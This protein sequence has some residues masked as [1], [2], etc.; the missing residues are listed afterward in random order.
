MTDKPENPTRRTALRNLGLA[1]LGATAAF[2]TT[3]AS[4]QT[5]ASRPL[6]GK[7]AI[8]TGARNNQGRAFCAALAE[9]GA[10]VVVHYHRAET[11]GEAEETARMVREAGAKAALIQGDL[12]ESANVKALYDL[13]EAEFGGA[14]IVINTA[15]TI[16]KKPMADFTDD[17]F[18]RLV[19]DNTK[20]TFYSM[21]EAARRLRDGGR[22]INIGTS[23]TAGAAPGY[24][25]YAGTKAPVEDF[26]RCLSK[27]LGAR[28]ITVN[29]IAPGP[30]DNPFFH[31]E[32][33]PQSVAY[34]T[35]LSV[36][37]RLGTEQDIV[38]LVRY[39]ALPDS[40]WTN[41]QTLFANGGYLTR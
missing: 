6:T 23:L 20:T 5:P 22:I 13:A 3:A 38:P 19:N 4:G 32:E 21:R 16:I 40:Q 17:E 24:A 35:N 37:K 27:E 18:E 36:E 8:V 7:V 34:A 41:G 28:G 14:D 12:G 1:G 10:N 15:G 9:M 29:N 25:G 31:G 39:L 11:A 33:N 30:L 26:G 2:G